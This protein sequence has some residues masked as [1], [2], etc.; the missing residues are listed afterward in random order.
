MY[1]EVSNRAVDIIAKFIFDVTGLHITKYS[2]ITLV[3]EDEFDIESIS[4]ND[5][6]FNM[7]Y[8]V[9]QFVDSEDVID[10]LIN[11]NV[12]A[13]MAQIEAQIV[14][15]M[16]C[17]SDKEYLDIDGITLSNCDIANFIDFNTLYSFLCKLYNSGLVLFQ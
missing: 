17:M 11:K 16:C 1:I 10:I 8:P 3:V 15:I 12:I 14:Y 5:C 2:E 7:G 6:G 13:N 4:P 9:Y